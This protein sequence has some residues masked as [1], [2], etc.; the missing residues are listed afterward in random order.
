[1]LKFLGRIQFSIEMTMWLIV[2]VALLGILKSSTEY[3]Y[4]LV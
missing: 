4:S 2:Y 1:M 3:A